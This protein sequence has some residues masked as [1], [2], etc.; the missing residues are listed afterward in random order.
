MPFPPD[1]AR[2]AEAA[3]L[4]LEPPYTNQ[5]FTIVA[6]GN[7]LPRTWEWSASLEQSFSGAQ[8]I[9]ATYTG[10]AGRQLLRRYFYAFDAVVRSTRHFPAR[11]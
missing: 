4:S 2:S 8:R 1:D 9:T 5:D 7:T 11:G 3:P 6:P 10:H